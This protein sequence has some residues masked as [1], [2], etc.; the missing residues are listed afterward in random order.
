MPANRQ[1][2]ARRPRRRGV[3]KLLPV[4]PQT[5]DLTGLPGEGGFTRG[6][7]TLGPPAESASLP[8]ESTSRHGTLAES[9]SRTSSG[10]YR[11][12]E[13][14]QYSCRVFTGPALR[15]SGA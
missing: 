9:W 13:G 5:L 11:H 12:P 1:G 3:Q 15:G 14:R 2:R 8:E 4:G 6:D 7:R 10:R